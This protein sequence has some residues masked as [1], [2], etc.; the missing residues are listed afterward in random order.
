MT[1]MSGPTNESQRVPPYVALVRI[2]A[3]VGMSAAIAFGLFLLLA[4]SDYFLWG[5][6]S[7]V[8]AIPF[9]VVMR[10]V[11]GTAEAG[12]GDGGTGGD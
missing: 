4:G 10:L 3:V 8:A 1:V 6:V 9:F 12:E 7:L 2:G 5:I 11:E